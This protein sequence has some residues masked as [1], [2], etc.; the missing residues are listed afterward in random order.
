MFQYPIWQFYWNSFFSPDIVILAPRPRLSCV[1]PER[2]FTALH[3][4]VLYLSVS[5]IFNINNSPL[6]SM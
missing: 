1:D 3:W 6:G 2:W 5:L 4:Y